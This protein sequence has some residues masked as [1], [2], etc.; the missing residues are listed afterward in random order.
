[1]SST[2]NRC[3]TQ[4]YRAVNRK[5]CVVFSGTANFVILQEYVFHT[6]YGISVTPDLF[7]F[8]KCRCIWL[9]LWWLEAASFLRIHTLLS[10]SIKGRKFIPW[11]KA[12]KI[13]ISEM[14]LAV[15]FF[16]CATIALVTEWAMKWKAQHKYFLR[17]FFSL[18]YGKLSSTLAESWELPSRLVSWSWPKGPEHSEKFTFQVFFC[19]VITIFMVD[20][21]IKSVIKA[22]T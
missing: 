7:L 5:Y 10:I 18:L 15:P 3:P 6:F 13:S 9:L 11:L 1:M 4:T 8:F 21:T 12:T 22:K 2:A 17:I 14:N 16:K 19:Y 20:H